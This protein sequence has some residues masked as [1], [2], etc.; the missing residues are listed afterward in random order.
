LKKSIYIEIIKLVVLKQHNNRKRLQTT[1][2]LEDSNCK[3]G[4]LKDGNLRKTKKELAWERRKRCGEAEETDED[5]G[6]NREKELAR[7]FLQC[8]RRS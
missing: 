6:G 1:N 7:E 2:K 5:N 8:Q 3:R 4:E